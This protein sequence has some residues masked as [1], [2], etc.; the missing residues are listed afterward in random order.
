MD[1]ISLIDLYSDFAFT[2]VLGPNDHSHNVSSICDEC[3]HEKGV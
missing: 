1:L 3:I 2:F